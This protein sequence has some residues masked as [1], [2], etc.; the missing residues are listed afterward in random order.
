[1]KLEDCRRNIDEID[2]KIIKLLE[3]RL[4]ICRQV[5][6]A[7]AISGKP[8]FDPVRENSKLESLKQSTASEY[9]PYIL[10]I[11][12]EIMK[13]CR[14]YQ[15]DNQADYGLL[16][17][18]LKHS[19]SPEL[20]R[21]LGGYKY[22]LY[23]MEPEDVEAFLKEGTFKGLNVTIPYKKTVM[24]Y[25]QSLSETAGKCGSVNTIVKTEDG[26]LYGE[27]TDYY[28]LGYLLDSGGFSVA[29]KKVLVL[30]NGG[31]AA[32]VKKLLE[33]KQAGEIVTISRSGSD[34]YDNIEKHYDGEFII[35]TTPVGMYPDNG[36]APIDLRHFKKCIGVVDLIY[37]PLRTKLVLDAEDLGIPAEG[38]L[39]M[40]IGQ[41][42]RTAEI[43]TG[44]QI[45][46]EKVAEAYEQIKSE[47]QNIVLIGMPGCGKTT[48]GRRISKILGRKF[49]DC[50]AAIKQ[51][52]GMSPKE[53]IITQGEE[54]FRDIEHQVLGNLTKE[55][56]AVISTGG[57]VVVRD[58]N[59]QL[60]KENG[61]IVYI[62]R[63]ISKLETKSRPLSANNN[64]AELYERRKAAYEGWSD[65]T[66]VNDNF[67]EAVG[68]LLEIVGAKSS[69]GGR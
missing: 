58:E 9:E 41:G 33:D 27:N 59:F 47:F 61:L 43:F 53:I 10:E 51:E 15:S 67:N 5:G 35:N 11:V 25:C 54:K 20:H 22:N 31:A 49:V 16:G 56:G 60:L 3:K 1:M 48:I 28:G 2:E 19:F 42:K 65:Y 30:G 44:Q 57:G 6:M 29:G 24:N 52:T 7:K 64:T 68:K 8:I 32:T 37:N 4:Y 40:L 12:A 18:T 39:R 26:A 50:D 62:K 36:K 63:Q 66:V 46:D 23:E 38:G 45:P 14:Q 55:T 69:G 17:R 34:N 21:R 13:E